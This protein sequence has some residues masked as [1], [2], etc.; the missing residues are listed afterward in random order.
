MTDTFPEIGRLVHLE[1]VNFTVD[2]H[3]LATVFLMG[4][5]GFTRDPYKRTDHHNMGV[6]VGMQQFHLPLRSRPTP[7][8][9]G[10]VGLIVPDLKAV[11]ERLGYI[12]KDGHFKGTPYKTQMK[13]GALEIVSPFGVALRLHQAGKLAFQ[14][15]VGIPYVDIHVAPG[16]ARPLARY[17]RQVM[18]CPASVGKLGGE[19]VCR[20]TVGPNQE[21]RFR[22]RDGIDHDLHN[23]HVA[24]Y[25]ADYNALRDTAQA[26]ASFMGDARDQTFF[27]DRLYD[28]DNGETILRFQH[29]M[30]GLFHADYMRQLVNRW[31]MPTEPFEDQ[32]AIRRAQL[33]AMARK[34]EKKKRKRKR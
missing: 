21:L 23:F 14:R 9:P 1:H 15:P 3:D 5:L 10:V 26:N 6:N 20:V 4:G 24:I 33:A 29:E 11:R 32:G 13:A 30:R 7:P 8:F 25:T 18:G 19:T 28:P 31:P 27:L 12:E 22:E 17:Y 34:P 2:D 16:S